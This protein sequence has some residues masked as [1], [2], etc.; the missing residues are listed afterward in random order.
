MRRAPVVLIAT[1]VVGS[2]AILYNPQPQ[3]KSGQTVSGQAAGFRNT[4]L[5][6][7]IMTQY[8]PAQVKIT[9]RSNRIT[10]VEP[11][12]LPE[13][14]PRSSQISW[15]AEPQLKKQA[16]TAQSA[17]IDGVTGATYTTDGYV[18]S[19]ASAIAKAGL[20]TN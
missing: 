11:V 13:N 6:D 1:A 3:S 9:I 18:Q 12:L 5:G 20:S 4:Y 17:Q 10:A 16:L 15:G 14:D 7:S 19:L 8:G 2:G